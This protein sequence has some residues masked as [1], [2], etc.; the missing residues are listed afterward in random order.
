MNRTW[1]VGLALFCV[2]LTS[3]AQIALKLGVS[4]GA[5][6]SQLGGQFGF[7]SRAL[8]APMVIAGLG[9]YA[10]STLLWLFVLAKLDV[11]YAYPFVSL[12]FVFTALYGY[13]AMDEPMVLARIAGISLIVVGVA[14]VARS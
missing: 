13:F 1:S 10:A 9:L 5:M 7:L 11:S 12:G 14:L 8:V 6:Q 4:G 3:A 2:V